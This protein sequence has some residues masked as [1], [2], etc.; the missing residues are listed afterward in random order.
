MIA[1]H[2]RG[3]AR[4]DAADAYVEHLRTDTFAECAPRRR[5]WRCSALPRR[6]SALRG[7]TQSVEAVGG[8]DDVA[9]EAADHVADQI[10]A[11]RG[12]LIDHH[13][14]LPQ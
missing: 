11:E 8:D 1:R 7:R 12:F 10:F 2:W 13:L 6:R 3:L 14:Q 9:L 4:T 5:E